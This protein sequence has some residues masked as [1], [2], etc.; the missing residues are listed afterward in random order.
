MKRHVYF[1]ISTSLI[2]SLVLALAGCGSGAQSANSKELQFWDPYPQHTEGSAWDSYVKSCA[3][4]G[5]TIKR[6]GMPQNDVLNK[7]TTAVKEDNAPDVVLLDNPFMPTAVDAGLITDL[8]KAGVNTQVLDENIEG[9]GLVDGARYGLAFGSNALGLYYNPQILE[10]AG[11]DP[12]SIKSWDSLNDAIK[13]VVDSGA[14]GIT[15]SGITGEEG[16]FQFL[17]WFWGSGAKLTNPQSDKAKAALDLVSGWVKNGWAPKSV[18]T[19]NQSAAWDLFLTGEYGFAEN[20]SWQA[21]SA[22]EKGY[23]VLPIPS[24]AGGVAPVPTGGEMATLPFHKNE[25]SEKVKA[26]AQVITCMT[27]DKNLAK[28]NE[29]LGYLAAKQNVREAQAQANKQWEPWVDSVANAEGRT[30]TVGLKYEQISATLSK[31]LQA[32]LNR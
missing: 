4:K 20:G 7:L 27:N 32:A 29:T 24:Q 8:T 28:T 23:K 13:K 21:A 3:P 26:A 17:P 5:Y 30:S 15:F 10:K 31:D 16:V 22:A 14:K 19:D 9:P 6:Q 1:V 18:A 11:V 12:T 2:S 25:N